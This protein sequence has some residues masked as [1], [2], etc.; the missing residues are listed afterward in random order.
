MRHA[1]IPLLLFVFCG[2][3]R[4]EQYAVPPGYQLVLLP[5]AN[6]PGR[7]TRDVGRGVTAAGLLLTALAIVVGATT[8]AEAAE[9]RREHPW[10]G[11]GGANIIGKITAGCLGSFGA[12]HVFTGVALWAGGARK[13]EASQRPRLSLSASGM[14]VTF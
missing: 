12:A 13:M 5:I 2:A 9:L 10:T 14:A 11:E 7:V 6:Q 8:E 1:F 3:A 4:A